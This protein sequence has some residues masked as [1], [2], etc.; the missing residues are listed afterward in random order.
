VMQISKDIQFVAADIA[1][2]IADN[3]YDTLASIYSQRTDEVVG[4]VRKHGVEA[5]R[6]AFGRQV[7]EHNRE[8]V[9]TVADLMGSLL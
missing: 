6:E 3:V 2:E 5:V 4:L 1:R 9:N 7:I 8:P